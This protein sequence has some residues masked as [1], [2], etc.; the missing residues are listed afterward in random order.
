MNI[1]GELK[2][3]SQL[4]HIAIALPGCGKSNTCVFPYNA[5][6]ILYEPMALCRFDLI[7]SLKRENRGKHHGKRFLVH[8]CT[9]WSCF[10]CR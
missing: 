8:K 2:F 3:N 5:C 4:A 6:K 9:T 10:H 1:S 7:F